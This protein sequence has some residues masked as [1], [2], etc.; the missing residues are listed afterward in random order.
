[1]AA[2]KRGLVGGHD[3]PKKDGQKD[4]AFQKGREWERGEIINLVMAVATALYFAA[5]IG[6]FFVMLSANRKTEDALKFTRE[7]FEI[8]HRPYL[9]ATSFKALAHAITDV[10]PKEKADQ[11]AISVA[12]RN[13]GSSHANH[14]MVWPFAS[15]Q[16]CGYEF[17]PSGMVPPTPDHLTAMAS[18][19]IGE[20][21]EPQLPRVLDYRAFGDDSST[22]LYSGCI[23]IYQDE[24]KK[25][26]TY[27]FSYRYDHEQWSFYR[28][29]RRIGP[30]T[31]PWL[32]GMLTR[33]LGADEIGPHRAVSD[34]DQKLLHAFFRFRDPN[35]RKR[36]S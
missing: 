33:Y 16:P 22:H 31:E 3:Q 9:H 26:H 5:T 36:S 27:W 20:I 13:T 32:V 2:K 24:F 34:A 6:I 28:D 30:L 21:Y 1:M 11:I 12:L 29:A 8:T 15:R 7:T 17:D 18:V 19:G 4:R 23:V 14:V 10:L 25:W 35:R